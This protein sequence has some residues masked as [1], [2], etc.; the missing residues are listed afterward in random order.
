MAATAGLQGASTSAVSYLSYLPFGARTLLPPFFTPQTG[1]PW[2]KQ[3]RGWG[4]PQRGTQDGPR[5]GPAPAVLPHRIRLQQAPSLPPSLGD[6]PSS[7]SSGG[8]AGV[9]ALQLLQEVPA[10]G[11]IWPG[12]LGPGGI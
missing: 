3:V 5:P 6:W 11:L 1:Q 12:V 10:D 7:G 9:R 8:R 4:S 2:E